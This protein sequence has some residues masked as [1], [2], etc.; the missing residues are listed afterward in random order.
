MTDG[1]FARR[2]GVAR[3]LVLLL[4]A[5]GCT[6]K[7]E[8]VWIQFNADGDLL[9][10]H[11]GGDPADAEDCEPDVSCPDLHS[12]VEG[13][14]IGS[15]TADPSSGPV[16]TEHRLLAIVGDDWEEQVGRV[17]VEAEGERGLDVFELQRDPANRGAWGVSLES[18][19][20]QGEAR[21]DAWTVRL[22]EAVLEEQV[23]VTT[24]E[25]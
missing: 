20:R 24:E 23:D 7:D 14:V 16:G 15:A 19:G 22:F 12:L 8:A 6:K 5:A 25:G 18:L 21:V 9:E 10:V 4:F 17:T 11:V 1:R 2:G 3:A 13:A